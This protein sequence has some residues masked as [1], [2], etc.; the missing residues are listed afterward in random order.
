[1]GKLN[2]KGTKFIRFLRALVQGSVL[3]LFVF[4]AY[5]TAHAP[6]GLVPFNFLIRL[7]PSAAILSAANSR[8]LSVLTGY[9]PAWIM[10]LL[11]LS[12][13]RFFCGW[14]CPLGTC[15]DA[16]GA[17][18]PH[19]LKKRFG[20]EISPKNLACDA[21][22]RKIRLRTK[23]ALLLIVVLLSFL[24]INMLFFTS[25][26]SILNRAITE[27][28]W[29]MLPFFFIFLLVISFILPRRFWCESVCP[30][31]ALISA[32]AFAG[33]ALR[34]VTN[35]F[36]VSKDPSLCIKCAKCYLK[37]DFG[38]SEPFLS[39][40][41]G[42]VTSSEC[43]SCGDCV[44]ACPSAGAL[45]MTL[46]G[47]SFPAKKNVKKVRSTFRG[48]AKRRG[49]KSTRAASE[50]QPQVDEN[51]VSALGQDS[52][53]MET[54]LG[55]TSLIVTRREFVTGSLAFLFLSL[56][57]LYG[58]ITDKP[59]DLLRMPGAQDEKRFLS[60]C[61]RCSECV[62]VCP[63][64]CLFPTGLE[65]GF[66][67][68]W[69]PRFI[70]REASCIFDQCSHACAA[71]CPTGAIEKLKPEQVRIGTA[72][73]N[74]RRCLGYRGQPCLVCKERCRFNVI[75]AN[76][77]RPVVIADLCTGCGSCENTCPTEPASI[78]VF[79]Q[80]DTGFE[81]GGG[82]RRRGGFRF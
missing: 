48:A 61:A 13:G 6:T 29:L 75:E 82:L 65:G 20:K 57:Y 50:I 12:G 54:R 25:P 1:M 2:S 30:T 7:D 17:I 22:K 74:K 35:S 55:D 38:V 21:A 43:T 77:L 28:L 3:G 79:A 44:I 59:T 64:N 4:T 19:A 42:L 15:F 78:R 66:Q 63:A 67:R 81:D 36:G 8:S 80:G 41:P 34:R 73:V 27:M 32:F 18:K 23:F 62:K 9:Y 10:L 51:E 40:R 47:F 5:K 33:K 26:L 16:V 31:G 68:I 11:F 24:G 76:G 49:G 45:S 71:S 46:L 53:Y 70:P 58:A 37:C 60:L 52:F 39:D 69:T 72:H 56:G 14:I